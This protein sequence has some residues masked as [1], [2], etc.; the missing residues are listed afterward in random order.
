M[1][2]SNYQPPTGDESA[3]E[4]NS[5]PMV[6]SGDPGTEQPSLASGCFKWGCLGVMVLVVLGFGTASMGGGM[7]FITLLQYSPLILLGFIAVGVFLAAKGS[8]K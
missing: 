3:P 2:E 7:A 6:D 5:V 4:V 1:S 8:G